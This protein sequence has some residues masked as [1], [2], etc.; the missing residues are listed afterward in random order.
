MALPSSASW[1]PLHS[2]GVENAY[3]FIS[4]RK[5][6]PTPCHKFFPPLFSHF[7]LKH[8]I[9]NQFES[10]K[11]SLNYSVRTNWSFRAI[12][13]FGKFENRLREIGEIFLRSLDAISRKNK[14]PSLQGS[15]YS[16]S[17]LCC[18]WWTFFYKFTSPK[19]I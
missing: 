13:S 10:F 7:I 2:A 11:Q 15:I 17:V 4:W 8:E 14:F 12:S 1:S 6:Q 18:F 19:L 5:W 9:L 16:F 3:S